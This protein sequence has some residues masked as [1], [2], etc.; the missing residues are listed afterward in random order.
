MQLYGLTILITNMMK[1][2][3]LS[4][5]SIFFMSQLSSQ[6]YF[7]F[8]TSDAI[9][10]YKVV[11]SYSYPHEWVVIDS[12]GQ[13]VTID[14]IQYVEVYSAS[15][16]NSFLEGAIRED[17][18]QKKVY[19]RHNYSEDEMLLYDFAT[20]AGD[21]IYYPTD[22]QGNIDYYKVVNSVDSILIS[23]QYRKRWFL[24][25]SFFNMNDIW[26][27]GIGSVY[28]YGLLYPLLPDIV[29][30]GS[31]PCFGCF[32]HDTTLYVDSDNCSG[33][34]PCTEWLVE[35]QEMYENNKGINLF[36]NPLKN[37]LIVE[38]YADEEVY[39]YIEVYTYD[40]KLIRTTTLHSKKVEIDFSD[41][42]KGVYFLK[43][44]GNQKTVLKRII[45]N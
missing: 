30:D 17:T 42:T 9:W 5:I 40:A 34:C 7:R 16:G 21:T 8:P 2:L 10:N 31:T 26:I 28:R 35:T 19:F 27:E 22:I 1:K 18:L 15:S 3:I 43:F 14:N 44:I 32:S 41:L 36:P 45:K 6:D 37:T 39:Q 4:L 38:F 33:T 12:L 23:S 25:N 20:E 11:G 13:Q 24:T 29:L